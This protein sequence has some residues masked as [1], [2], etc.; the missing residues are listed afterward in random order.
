MSKLSPQEIKNLQIKLKSLD[1]DNRDKKNDQGNNSPAIESL[2]QKGIPMDQ[3]LSNLKIGMQELSFIKK[4]GGT[5]DYN[6]FMDS[7]T[8][9][10]Q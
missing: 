8:I 1:F 2:D 3:R 4:D 7:F 5:K 10:E 9:E 6:S